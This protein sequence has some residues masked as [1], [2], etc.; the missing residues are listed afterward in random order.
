[1]EPSKSTDTTTNRT[2]GTLRKKDVLVM[3]IMLGLVAYSISST[4]FTSRGR[5]EG[6]IM[7][8]NSVKIESIEGKRRE[9]KPGQ[10]NRHDVFYCPVP[11]ESVDATFPI[12]MPQNLSLGK[13]WNQTGAPFITTDI[14]FDLVDNRRTFFLRPRE[15][16]FPPM[17]QLRDWIRSRPHPI[18]LI[19][20]NNQDDSWPADVDNKDYELIL[21]ETNLHAV[22]ALNA[23]ELVHYPK[24][25]PL[26]IGNKWQY[27]S[28][29][30]FGESKTK[31]KDIYSS[32]STSAKET[33]K[34]FE[35]KN[36]TS[37]VWV[38]PMS[39]SN[40]RTQKYSRDTPALKLAR[41][42]ICSVLNT[43]SP[44]TVVCAT[45]KIDQ[46][47]Y[48]DELR[49]HRFLVSPAGNGLDSHSTW[50]A[51]LVGCIPIVPRSPLDPLF[52]DLPVWLV[53][54]WEEVTDEAVL[55]IE[56]ELKGKEF[57]WEKM[58]ASGW[59]TELH[60]GLCTISPDSN[61]RQQFADGAT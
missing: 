55:R 61:I 57:K 6:S 15:R 35:N 42:E 29:Q 28:A 36:R 53:G 38:R 59:D 39:D 8:N 26:P 18:T 45:K 17:E 16:G 49:K 31:M 50:E 37:T 23:R 40:S 56:Q 14:W 46:A 7:G 33:Q 34:L 30:L 24:L 9:A 27:R 54:S 3:V 22:Y 60:K 13:F 47:E 32:V 2:F 10:A 21:N 44:E 4:F 12:G 5:F 20:N 51:L 11:N 41:D 48:F 58:F 43:T 19:M 25:K 52:E 1:M